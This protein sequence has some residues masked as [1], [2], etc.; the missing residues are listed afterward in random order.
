MPGIVGRFTT[1]TDGAE[2][3]AKIIAACL[4]CTALSLSA[5]SSSVSCSECGKNL[6]VSEDTYVMWRG[7]PL[8]GDCA[9][10]NEL[11]TGI[12]EDL[13]ICWDCEET[14]PKSSAGDMGVNHYNV[15]YYLCGSC[16]KQYLQDNGEDYNAG[17]KDGQADICENYVLLPAAVDELR[18][19]GREDA[20]DA[21]REIYVEDALTDYPSIDW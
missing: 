1:D 7:S 3:K 17:F 15:E 14:I 19:I 2:M 10:W 12:G 21:L 16:Y 9:A 11:A 6:N 13:C 20:I 8:C 5:C 18:A 4:A